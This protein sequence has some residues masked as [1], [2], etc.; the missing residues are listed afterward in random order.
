MHARSS[1]R[2]AIILAI[3]ALVLHRCRTGGGSAQAGPHPAHHARQSPG[4]RED[5]GVAGVEALNRQ[6][7]ELLLHRVGRAP[8]P[9]GLANLPPAS[10]S[11]TWTP[12]PTRST[13]RR[14]TPHTTRQVLSNASAT[15]ANDAT[16]PTAP[17]GLTVQ[18]V[19]GSQVLLTFT[20]GVDAV[21][22]EPVHQVLINGVVTPNTLSTTAPGAP[23]PLPAQRAH[24]CAT[25][26]RRRRTR[27][28][29]AP[30]MRPVT[31]PV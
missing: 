30:L 14:G 29:C 17:S 27:S 3:V 19:V 26:N 5:H 7:G 9:V 16:R 13:C 25:S 11:V 12:A 10:P 2:F 21:S 18:S 24:G 28:P 23:R 22:K 15:T 8:R 4:H 1:S 20:A 31:P 6:L